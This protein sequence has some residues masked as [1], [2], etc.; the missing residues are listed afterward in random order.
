M[1]LS[2]LIALVATVV[3]TGCASTV[4]TFDSHG[5]MIGSCKAERGFIIGG[6]QVVQVLQTKKA[7][8]VNFF[9]MI[10]IKNR[11]K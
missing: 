3:L 8:D 1:K 6:A 11:A 4:T 5:R 9:V 7:V 10:A 2:A